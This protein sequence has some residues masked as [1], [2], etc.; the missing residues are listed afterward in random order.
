M[1]KMKVVGHKVNNVEG[2]VVYFDNYLYRVF[3][4]KNKIYSVANRYMDNGMF[5][6]SAFR[7][8]RSDEEN[9]MNHE[10]LCQE[11]RDNDLGFVSALG[12]YVENKKNEGEVQ[13]EELS[14]IVPYR[15]EV[16]SE[17]DFVKLA[18]DL[19][20]EFNQETVLVCVPWMFDGKPTY[21]TSNF[22]VDMQFKKE[23][24][25]TKEGEHY[26]TKIK[27][28]AKTN[29]PNAFTYRDAISTTR[30]EVQRKYIGYRIPNN[31]SQYVKFRFKYKGNY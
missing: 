14:I 30:E 13:V 24:S 2:K 25:T 1:L 6:I 19:C 11:I 28:R 5:V 15:K 16:I 3:D 20:K 10:K 9:L 4:A 17:E 12:G 29:T 31:Q 27:N 22:D 7:N 23:F 18:V 26:Y 21:L 8:E